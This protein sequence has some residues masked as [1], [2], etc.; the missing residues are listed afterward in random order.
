MDLAREL[1]SNTTLVDVALFSFSKLS[2]VYTI[3]FSLV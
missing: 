2:T 3:A 1:F